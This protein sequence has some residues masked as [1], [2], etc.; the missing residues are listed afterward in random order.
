MGSC[1]NYLLFSLKVRDSS[2]ITS[3]WAPSCNVADTKLS[4]YI[5]F[6]YLKFLSSWLPESVVPWGQMCQRGNPKSLFI[7]IL[8]LYANTFDLRFIHSKILGY[9]YKFANYEVVGLR[10]QA[11]S[12]LATWRNNLAIWQNAILYRVFDLAIWQNNL[13]IWQNR[14]LLNYKTILIRDCSRSN[15]YPLFLLPY[16]VLPSQLPPE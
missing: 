2:W 15:V 4:K 16:L 12:H 6:L 9:L 14:G 13:A 11:V 1:S 7:G 3:Q 8:V 5:G 10:G